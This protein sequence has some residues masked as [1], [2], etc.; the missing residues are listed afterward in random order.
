MVTARDAGMLGKS[1]LEHAGIVIASRRD[2]YEIAR[3]IGGLLES[4]EITEFRNQIF[5]I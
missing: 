5:Y 4:V 2:V 3:R 1:Q